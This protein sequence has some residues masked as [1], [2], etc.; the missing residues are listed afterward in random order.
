MWVMHHLLQN[1]QMKQVHTTDYSQ[2]SSL[3]L[4]KEDLTDGISIEN[5]EQILEDI[6]NDILYAQEINTSLTYT[7]TSKFE[8][9]LSFN[10]M[11]EIDKFTENNS[12]LLSEFSANLDRLLAEDNLLNWSKKFKWKF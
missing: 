8:S 11:L 10:Q 12:E 9:P 1:Q 5:I 3:C 7:S 4:F 2:E 6:F